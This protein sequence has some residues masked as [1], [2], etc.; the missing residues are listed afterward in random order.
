LL[1]QNKILVENHDLRWRDFGVKFR[2][3]IRRDGSALIK[4]LVE[5]AI[6]SSNDFNHK[7]DNDSE[8]DNRNTEIEISSLQEIKT[9]TKK[10]D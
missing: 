9:I 4:I 8:V 3:K 6:L 5:E 10:I 2:G 7:L 1:G